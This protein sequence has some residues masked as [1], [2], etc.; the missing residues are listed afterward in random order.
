MFETTFNQCAPEYQ[1]KFPWDTSC[2]I[3]LDV[4]IYRH[5]SK[6]SPETYFKPTNL[7]R[8]LP[9]HSN[10]PAMVFRSWIG[11]EIRRYVITNSSLQ[12][13]N[14]TIGAFRSRLRRC[15]DDDTMLHHVFANT[16]QLYQQRDE[17][18]SHCNHGRTK[19]RIISMV[20]PYDPFFVRMGLSS[21]VRQI[22]IQLSEH[23]DLPAPQGVRT[24]VAFSSE[25]N[26]LHVLRRLTPNRAQYIS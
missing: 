20:L 3:S 21:I 7:F 14:D 2:I 18:L 13:F 22:G 24:L 17:M 19:P 16:T 23:L 11:A 25:A 1:A 9:F 4:K 26:L 6:V 15:G 12:S 8:Y 5:G 10:H